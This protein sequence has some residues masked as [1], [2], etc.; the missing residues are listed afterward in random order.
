MVGMLSD[1]GN[2]RKVNQDS[3]GYFEEGS[4]RLYVVADGMGGHNAGEVAS[5]VAI[6]TT[7]DYVKD[8][9]MR[10]NLASVLEEA[11]EKANSEIYKLA[12]EDKSMNGM[13]TTIT[14]CY[15]RDDKVVMGNVGDSSGII[16]KNNIIKKVTKDHSFV[17]ELIDIG[18]ISEEEALN[19]PNKNI[20]T[21]ALGTK[22]TVKVDIFQLDIEG[23]WKIILCTDG[24]S[25]KV[26]LDEMY[27]IILKYGDEACCSELINLSKAKDS[28][29]NISV[30]VFEGEG[31]D[32]RNNTREQV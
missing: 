11:I 29:D 32:D 10:S 6:N 8:N 25:N 9:L 26:T 7:I 17:Q 24:L 30:I 27:D 2:C 31:R 12:Q 18:N 23:I 19:H 13:G 14:A 3:V 16:I 5:K 22:E 28:K 15:I 20:I 4:N 1:I 21:R